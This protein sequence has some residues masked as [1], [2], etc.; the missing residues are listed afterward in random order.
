MLVI[1]RVFR[2]E[3]RYYLLLFHIV[4][5]NDGNNWRFKPPFDTLMF[6][7]SQLLMLVTKEA[8][9]QTFRITEKVRNI[10]IPP[11][12]H[13]KKNKTTCF[14]SVIFHI[15]IQ[16]FT[17]FVFR[18]RCFSSHRKGGTNKK[19]WSL[20]KISNLDFQIPCLDALPLSLRLYDE[21]GPSGS[22][23]ITHVLHTAGISNF[24]VL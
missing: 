4:I 14:I 15:V 24:N 7:S 12:P 8:L 3:R 21:Q 11:P 18:E 2:A 5:N 20:H 17:S 10:P 13:S 22:S 6:L 23:Y 19:F 16:I 9:L 1:L